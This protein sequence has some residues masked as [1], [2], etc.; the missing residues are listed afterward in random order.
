MKWRDIRD[1]FGERLDTAAIPAVL[2]SVTKAL[3]VRDM[4]RKGAQVLRLVSR[5]SRLEKDRKAL[6]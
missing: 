4:S 2:P 1:K 5:L 3:P 6:R